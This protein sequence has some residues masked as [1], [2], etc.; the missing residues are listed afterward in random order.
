ME[1]TI[2]M[3]ATAGKIQELYQTLQALLPTLRKAKGCRDCR[4]CRDVEDGEIFILKMDWDTRTSLEQYLRS[5]SGSALFG[6]VDLLSEVARVRFGQD[7]S[8]EGI[9]RLKRMRAEP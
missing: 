4:I 1:L 5:A 3:K 7:A 9:D 2:E 6:A 8:W